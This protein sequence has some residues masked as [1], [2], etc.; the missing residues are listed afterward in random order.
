MD[1]YPRLDLLE[2][3]SSRCGAPTEAPPTLEKATRSRP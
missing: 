2:S 3:P 1:P